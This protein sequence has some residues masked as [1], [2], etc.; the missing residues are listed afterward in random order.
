M[1]RAR[2][3]REPVS[4]DFTDVDWFAELHLFLEAPPLALLEP[5]EGSTSGRNL[6]SAAS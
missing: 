1:K 6:F 3:D 5:H 2:A 4:C